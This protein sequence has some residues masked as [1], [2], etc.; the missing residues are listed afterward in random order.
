MK[1]TYSQIIKT[2][3]GNIGIVT[4]DKTITKVDTLVTEKSN[5]TNNDIEQQL[6]NYFQ[7]PK[8]KFTLKTKPHGTPFQ[9]RVW[10]ALT[11]IPSGKTLTYGELAKKLNSSP[12]AVG[13]ACRHNPIP[14]I[15]PCH[16]VVGAA[17]IGGYAGKSQGEIANIKIWLLKHEGF[18][19]RLDDK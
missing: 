3:L 13:Q 12:R 16:R 6:K 19:R 7:N 14:I 8:H 2:P 11:I 4:Q 1:N 10:Q 18:T 9:Q 17:S 5:N 15:I